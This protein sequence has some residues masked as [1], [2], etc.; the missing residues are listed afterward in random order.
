MSGGKRE[1][2]KKMIGGQN[3]FRKMLRTCLLV[4]SV[5]IFILTVFFYQR[6]ADSLSKNL[7]DD[8]ETN[9]EKSARTMNDLIREISQLYNT[10]ILDSR[11][12][13]FC[14]LKE[15]DPAENYATYL[16]VKKFYNINPYVNSLYIY[17]DA[18]KDAITCGSYR[19][20]LSYCWNYLKQ[21]KKS[22]VF[23]SPLT[24]TEEEVLTFA[25]PVYADNFEELSGGIFI[26]LDM[27]KLSEHVLGT[28]SQA[29][30][31]LDQDG[32]VLLS[33]LPE[34]L[35]SDGGAYEAF[36]SWPGLVTA[37]SASSLR[38]FHGNQYLC[39][40]YKDPAQSLTFLSGVPYSEIVGPMRIQRNLSLAVA[41]AIFLAAILLQYF[42]TKRLY[43]PL[44]E[45]TEELRDSKYAQGSDTDEFSLIRRVYENAIDEIR[46]LEEENAFYQPRM[47]SDLIR[48]LILGN[49]DIG[50]VREILDKNGWEI[51]F[52]GMFVACFFIENSD[53]SDV[54]APVVQTRI[55]QHFH[56][57]LSPLFYTES[58][59]VASD[60]VVC[61]INTRQ[62]IP[63]TFDELVGLLESVKGKLLKD[64]HL[65][66]TISLDGVTKGIED[67]NR[68]YRRTLELKNYRFVLGFN[69][70]IY[71][72]RVMELM[73]EYMTYP[74][75]LA[76]EILSCMLHGNRD[77][78]KDNVQEFLSILRQ[79]S[80]QPASLLY[81]RL[82]L[83]LLFQMQRL[84]AP[85]KDSCL[86]AD[87]LHT[88]STLT[89]GASVLFTIFEW[90]QARK[91]AAEQLKDN[92]HFERIEESRKY[93]EAHYNDYNL[94]A[95][96]VADYLG[97]ST[98]YF[99]RI[100]KSI[101]GFYINDYIRQLRIVKAQELLMNSDMTITAV[102]EATGFSNPNYFY[103]IFKKE[104]GLTPAA[105]RK[106]GFKD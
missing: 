37:E 63:I 83:D 104:T 44:E 33:D 96:M 72:G 101:T 48:G 10:V 19:F 54:L 78:F 82:Y 23:P 95:G 70:I 89:E 90:Y 98:N 2:I 31:V 100:F 18:A 11:V 80:Y 53:A 57:A 6:Y 62:D 52:E 36:L 35:S 24:G 15:F 97:Y 26:N 105:Y 34:R 41:A 64:D 65:V 13:G 106:A 12:V 28:G 55:G 67:L 25:Y 92:K 91:A 69:Q 43:R 8:Q 14:E 46:E 17:N 16:I 56:E 81:N 85:D 58:V 60:Q 102:A 73:P 87:T 88:P 20:D 39:A 3:Y 45:I 94:S 74:D 59:P 7:Y 27:G 76:G 29:G 40:F 5:T 77:S 71:P 61:L 51:P 32:L 75:K 103:S 38:R 68:I 99:S 4:I 84:N 86:S 22:V 9:L 1:M 30:I 79:Y 42:I 66:L 50:Q 49:R 93:I 47:K 21:A